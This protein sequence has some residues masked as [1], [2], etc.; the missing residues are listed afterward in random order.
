MSHWCHA[1]FMMMLKGL[2]DPERVSSSIQQMW[3]LTEVMQSNQTTATV[4]RFDVSLTRSNQDRITPP[5]SNPHLAAPQTG[6]PLATELKPLGASFTYATIPLT[7]GL[8]HKPIFNCCFWKYD[9]SIR[10]VWC[11]W[12]C[13]K[14]FT[15]CNSQWKELNGEIRPIQKLDQGYTR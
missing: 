9:R 8:L 1:K 7:G 15:V 2:P 14:I 6:S 11:M 4:G 3:A 13:N 5:C 12:K 10:V